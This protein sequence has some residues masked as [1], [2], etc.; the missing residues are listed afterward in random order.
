[1]IECVSK[2]VSM[3]GRGNE[4]VSELDVEYVQTESAIERV[5]VS[6]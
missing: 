5:R 4:I 3:G 6:E 2:C 1:M